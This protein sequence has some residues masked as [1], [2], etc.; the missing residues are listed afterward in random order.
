MAGE[1]DGSRGGRAA[2]ND[3]PVPAASSQPLLFTLAAVQEENP[4]W[5]LLRCH[6]VNTCHTVSKSA[7]L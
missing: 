5:T 2:V 7:D 4:A 1:S 3:T 6:D